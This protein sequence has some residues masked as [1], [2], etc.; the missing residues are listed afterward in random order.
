MSPSRWEV[1]ACVQKL[2]ADC[3]QMVALLRIHVTGAYGTKG[4]IQGFL[5]A[6]LHRATTP[7]HNT[8]HW[9]GGERQT[10]KR[11]EVFLPGRHGFRESSRNTGLYYRSLGQGNGR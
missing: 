7:S 10:K 3:R 6:N 2:K 5:L 9:T 1:L 11:A 4:Q 8:V